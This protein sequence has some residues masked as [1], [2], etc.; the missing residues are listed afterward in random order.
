[1]NKEIGEAYDLAKL[2]LSRNDDA[3]RFADAKATFMLTISG[4]IFSVL[5]DKL[6]L[7]KQ[8]FDLLYSLPKAILVL[9]FV[10][11]SI[12]ILIATIST[13]YVV[14]PRTIRSK[15]TVFS[16][17]SDFVDREEDDCTSL[18]TSLSQE[19]KVQQIVSEIHIT[20]KI[21]ERKIKGIRIIT[22]GTSLVI[23]G[24]FLFY[25]TLVLS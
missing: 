25:F 11:M 17:F 10:V 19:E 9:S 2:V 12:G 21:I 8:N 13:I 4:L 14:F 24:L 3:T 16:H 23:L 18:L 6:D 7:V 5:I 20:S 1:M 22:I 15:T